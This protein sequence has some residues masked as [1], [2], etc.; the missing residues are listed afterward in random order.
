LDDSSGVLQIAETVLRV[1]SLFCVIGLLT[2]K[3]KK[4]RN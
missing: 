3:V 1:R 2:L 4:G